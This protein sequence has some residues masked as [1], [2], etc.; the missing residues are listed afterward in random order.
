MLVLHGI[1]TPHAMY[2]TYDHNRSTIRTVEESSN[3]IINL[4]NTHLPTIFLQNKD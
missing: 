4:I 2:L 1:R 3:F